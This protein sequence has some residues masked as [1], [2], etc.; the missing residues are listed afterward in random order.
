VIED[1]LTVECNTTTSIQILSFDIIK[2][3]FC[4]SSW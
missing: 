1:I 4:L 3:I 2:L